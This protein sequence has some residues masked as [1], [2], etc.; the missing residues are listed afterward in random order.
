MFTMDKESLTD[1]GRWRRLLAALDKFS[2]VLAGVFVNIIFGGYSVITSAALKNSTMSAIV[3]AFIR[4]ITAAAQLLGAAYFVESRKPVDQRRFWPDRADVGS[5]ILLGLLAIWGAQG[6]SALAIAN[7]TATYFSLLNP[8]QPV[9]ALLLSIVMGREVLT[10]SWS[11]WTKIIGVLVCV[12]GAVFSASAGGSS[13]ADS[14]KSESKNWVLGNVY[15]AFQVLLGGSYPVVQK[16]I[17]EKGYSPLVTAA[18]GYLFGAGLLLLSVATCCTDPTQWDI[19]RDTALALV[20]CS[21]LSSA[22]N[23]F[24]MAFMNNRMNPVFTAAFFPLIGMSAVVMSYF[25][26][27]QVPTGRELGGGAV[28]I[29]GLAAVLVAQYWQ[30][31]EKK[32]SEGD[33]ENGNRP[34]LEQQLITVGSKESLVDVA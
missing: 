3:Y 29:L 10:R 8:L 7:L 23:Y 2:P 19:N 15:L 30:L 5:F 9:V 17:L 26:L 21:V 27:G 34:E 12:C 14:A 16:G 28:I 11:S 25:F 18:W 22:V 24:L 32:K 20:Y 31:G 33:E 6:L 4:D 13:S 1:D